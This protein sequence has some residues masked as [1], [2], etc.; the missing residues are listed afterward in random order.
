MPSRSSLEPTESGP[1]DVRA[2]L[3]RTIEPPPR[4]MLC[5]SGIVKL[6]LTPAILTKAADCL[7]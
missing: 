5:T 1:T 6:V 2:L 3:T 4:A 7:G